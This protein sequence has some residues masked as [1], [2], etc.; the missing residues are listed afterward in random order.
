MNVFMTCFLVFIAGERAVHFS[1]VQHF[2][3]RLRMHS[4]FSSVFCRVVHFIEMQWPRENRHVVL[5]MQVLINYFVML[6]WPV[7]N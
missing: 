4:V 6:S 2:V 7:A 5:G 1:A 3:H